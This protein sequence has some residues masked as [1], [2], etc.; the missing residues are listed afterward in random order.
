[1]CIRD[2]YTRNLYRTKAAQAREFGLIRRD[3]EVNDWF[4]PKY[5]NAAIRELKLESFWTPHNAGDKPVA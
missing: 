1:M 3:I 2:R 4:E 5:L